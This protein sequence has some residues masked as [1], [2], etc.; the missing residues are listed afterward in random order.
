MIFCGDLSVPNASCGKNLLDAMIESRIF[1]DETVVINL[2]GVLKENNP[3]DTFWKV[4]NDKSVVELKQCCKK[5]IF[6]LANNHLYDYPLDIQPM[7]ATLRNNGILYFGLQNADGNITPLEVSCD[8]TDYALFGHCWEI[9]TKTNR[10]KLTDDRVVDCTYEQLY[11]TVV[12]YINHNPD[13]KVICCFHWNFDL[14]KYPFP[15]HKHLSHDLVDRGVEAVIGNHAHCQHEV[16]V[17]HGKVI[18]YGLGNFYMPD[19]YFFNGTLKYSFSS[20]NMCVIKLSRDNTLSEFQ[21]DTDINNTAIKLNEE[22]H[23]SLSKSTNMQYERYNYKEYYKRFKAMRVKRHLVP[24]FTT[25]H[26]SFCN[27]IKTIFCIERIHAIRF[28]RMSLDR[29]RHK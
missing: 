8:G 16:E 9:Y 13:K 1:K 11:W 19:G 21:F 20:H 14:E 17:Y 25:Y 29:I 4:Y 26:N 18:A 6:N 2:E 7:L 24:L 10:N 5:L 15:A 27:R 23:I 3:S 12:N 28:I 22:K